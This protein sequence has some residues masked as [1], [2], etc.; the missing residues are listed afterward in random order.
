MNSIFT[1]RLRSDGSF[2]DVEIEETV[3]GARDR[4]MLPKDTKFGGFGVLVSEGFVR[5][6]TAKTRK[7]FTL[8]FSQFSF[9]FNQGE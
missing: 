7:V 3:E 8:P 5:F 9:A 6:R 4:S 1:I 2:H